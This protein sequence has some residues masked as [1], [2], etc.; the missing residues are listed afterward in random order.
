MKNKILW[1]LL[2]LFSTTLNATQENGALSPLPQQARAA[3]FAARVL[4]QENY[5]HLPFDEKLSSAIFDNY[6]KELDGEKLIFLQSDIDQFANARP[7]FGLA[8]LNEDLS[9]PFAIFNLRQQRIAEH[10]NYSRSLLAHGFNFKEK[11]SL[12]PDRKYATWPKS[13]EEMND[14][15]RKRAKNDWLRLKLAGKDDK[16][17]VDILDKRYDNSLKSILRIKGD[18]VFQIFMDAY[19]TANDPHTN[20]FGV[21][22]AESFDISMK[23]SLTGIG[24]ELQYKDEYITIRHLVPGSPAE[25]SGKL[26]AGDRILAVGQGEKGPTS[27]VMGMS[28]FDAVALIRGAEDSVVRLDVLPAEAGPDGTHQLVTLIRKK[29]TLEN[30]SA[31][32]SIIDVQDGATTR[33]IGVI[34][35]PG[36][37][38]DFFAQKNGDNDF[39]SAARDVSLI[40]EEFKKEQVDGVLLDLRNNGGG[41]VEEAIELTGLFVEKGPVMQQLDSK[42]RVKVDKISAAGTPVWKGPFGVLINRAS[43]SASEIFAAA[44]QDYGR[45]IVIG[46]TSFGK[47]STQA[48]VNLDRLV[49]NDKPDFGELKMTVTKWFRINGDAIQLR[50]VTP[51][52]ILPMFTDAENFGE[53]SFDNA[54]PWGKIPATDYKSSSD[55]VHIVPTLIADHNA[56]VSKDKAF[57]DLQEDITEFKTQ[58]KKNLIS[59]N[60]DERRK[61]REA[62][63]AKVKLRKNELAKTKSGNSSEKDAAG[64]DASTR[65]DDGLLATERNFTNDKDADKKD[66]ADKDV[67]LKEAAHIIDDEA[68]L[69]RAK[70]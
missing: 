17:I 48:V 30:Q 26:K 29:I 42:D 27:D 36:F 34:S 52:I 64:T 43:A 7:Q 28:I 57:Q 50:G 20:Y 4:A 2:A 39:K 62:Q 63:K 23:L 5:E 33:H 13:K 65:Q 6:I 11:E 1:I 37:Y 44:I 31:K 53:S 70:R 16:G 69:L 38:R 49:K 58:R 18:D 8:L 67:L 40:L 3:H 68:S 22:A 60:E 10:L 66:S 19:A 21:R 41:S 54:L 9:I 45:G 47:G 14:L 59:L 12:Q 61:E 15:W 51:D 46:E 55:L 56:R 24:A 32:K 25:L 35:L